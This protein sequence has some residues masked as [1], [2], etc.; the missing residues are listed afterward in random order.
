MLACLFSHSKELVFT[1]VARLFFLC[2][3]SCA[4]NALGLVSSWP[5]CAHPFS[6]RVITDSISSR[7]Q[8]EDICLDLAS[9]RYSRAAAAF[10]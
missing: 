4:Y 8:P 2:L 5:Y 6:E 10:P 7:W 3:P 9:T 1:R